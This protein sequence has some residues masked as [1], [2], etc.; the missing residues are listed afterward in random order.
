M[1][2]MKGEHIQNLRKPNRKLTKHHNF[3]QHF[4]GRGN[5]HKGDDDFIVMLS[6]EHHQLFHKLFGLAT[7]RQA[8]D[9]LLR[10]DRMKKEQ[11]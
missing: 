2:E 10:L 9:I 5:G 1:R 11:R 4:G 8:A 6:P 3:A 7:F